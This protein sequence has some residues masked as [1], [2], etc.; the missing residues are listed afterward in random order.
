MPVDPIIT[1]QGPRFPED[2]RRGDVGARRRRLEAEYIDVME[3]FF[4]PRI[5]P[6]TTLERSV[7]NAYGGPPVPIR[8]FQP[9]GATTGGVFVYFFGGAWWLRSYNAPDVLDR[10]A[11]I[12]VQ[13]GVTV[14]EVDYPLAPENPYPA[15]IDAGESV[16]QWLLT[17][18]HGLDVEATRIALGGFSAGGNIAAAL[19]LRLTERLPDWRIATLILEAPVLDATQRHYTPYAAPPGEFE[20]TRQDLAAAVQL[21][22]QDRV[23]V[24]HPHVS[25]L[26]SEDLSAFPPTHILVGEY[27]ILAPEAQAFAGRLLDSGVE[28]VSLTFSGQT[29]LTH[30]LTTISAAARA[31]RAH[32]VSALLP[33]G[34]D[35]NALRP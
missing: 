13:A 26:L 19:T 10:C 32:V 14:V 16:I 22:I 5:S 12:A 27:D 28:V 21:Y 1:Q 6:A 18:R 9:P 17:D 4:P 35:A 3:R 25:P 20:Q 33:L 8:I 11:H 2:P 24:E 23:T 15:A 7:P 30:A 31:W 29:H 34:W